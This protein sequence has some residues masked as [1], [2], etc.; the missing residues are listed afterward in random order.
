VEGSLPSSIV[1]RSVER[2]LPS[3]QACYRTAAKAKNSTPAVNVKV[4]FVIDETGAAR[5]VAASGTFGSLAECVRSS[6]SRVQS[7]HAPDVGT[8]SVTVAISFTPT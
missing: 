3:L 5:R 2:V 8:V 6:M 4:R 1:R 7:P